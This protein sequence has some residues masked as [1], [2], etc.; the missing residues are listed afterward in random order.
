M[1]AIYIHKCYNIERITYVQGFDLYI[2]IIFIFEK[3]MHYNHDPIFLFY[4]KDVRSFKPNKNE[5]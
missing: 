5:D 4:K 2:K 3:D 1:H